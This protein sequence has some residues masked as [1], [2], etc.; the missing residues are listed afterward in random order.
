MDLSTPPEIPL[1]PG[2]LDY[3]GTV[4]GFLFWSPK[5]QLFALKRFVVSRDFSRIL[6]QVASADFHM[7][8]PLFSRMTESN[9]NLVLHP[10]QQAYAYFLMDIKAGP[11]RKTVKVF[12]ESSEIIDNAI[13][14]Q[15]Y[16]VIHFGELQKAVVTSRQ[17]QSPVS[18]RIRFLELRENLPKVVR[19]ALTEVF[20]TNADSQGNKEARLEYKLATVTKELRRGMVENYL[21]KCL[22][23]NPVTNHLGMMTCNDQRSGFSNFDSG[24][25]DVTAFERCLARDEDG[26]YEAQTGVANVLPVMLSQVK[27]NSPSVHIYDEAFRRAHRL[28]EYYSLYAGLKALC[29]VA[30]PV[31]VHEAYE[32]PEAVPVYL[33]RLVT[34]NP[35][36][37]ISMREFPTRHLVWDS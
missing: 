15:K 36:T 27:W 19:D 30:P 7:A 33:L 2:M 5:G 32:L 1:E 13:A 10:T 3:T 29:G 26:H 14:S 4:G 23:L 35:T 6:P 22:W 11:T 9:I 34:G 31:L 12:Q 21:V 8:Y 25:A 28:Q 37:Q 17:N 20:V 24:D 16:P 18:I